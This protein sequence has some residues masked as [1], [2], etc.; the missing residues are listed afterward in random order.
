MIDRNAIFDPKSL[1]SSVCTLAIF[2]VKMGQV[3]EQ[4]AKM[5]VTATALPRNWFSA[6]SAP[7]C[8]R[9]TKSGAGPIT[10]SPEWSWAV[11]AAGVDPASTVASRIGAAR[12]AQAFSSRLSSLRKRQSVCSAMT[13]CGMDLVK[14]ASFSRSAYQRTV[15]SGS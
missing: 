7:S 14:P 10:G 2:A 15:S 13:V 6:T 12:I 1:P 4:E 3:A 8:A 11:G 9:R 5:K